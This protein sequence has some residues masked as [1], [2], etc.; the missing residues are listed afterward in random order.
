MWQ[1][2]L[3]IGLSVMLLIGITEIAKRS[4][5]WG[6]ALASLPLT[7]LLAFV[8]LYLESGETEKV[9]A[10]SYGIFWLVL[11]SLVLFITLPILLRSGLNF[12]F[13]LGASCFITSIAYIVMIKILSFFNISL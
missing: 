13:S 4:S 1:Y 11:P 5:F 7:S 10:L 6:A 2:S 3:K 9:L 8:W 12:W